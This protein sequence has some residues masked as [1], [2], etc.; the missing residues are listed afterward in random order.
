MNNDDFEN[1]KFLLKEA[2]F[3]NAGPYNKT[4]MEQIRVIAKSC[5]C[6]VKF[7]FYGGRGN[8]DTSGYLRSVGTHPDYG[9]RDA[10]TVLS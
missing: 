9:H 2:G 10:G 3:R 5:D 8:P 7:A 6:Y 4:A 1:L